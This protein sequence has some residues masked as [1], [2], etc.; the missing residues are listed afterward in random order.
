M[1]RNPIEI[2]C[3]VAVIFACGFGWGKSFVARA[4]TALAAHRKGAKP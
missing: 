2:A 1:N 4:K 3:A